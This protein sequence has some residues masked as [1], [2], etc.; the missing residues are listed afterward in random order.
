MGV[1]EMMNLTKDDGGNGL[2]DNGADAS[3]PHLYIGDILLDICLAGC[4]ELETTDAVTVGTR[5]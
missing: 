1:D 4:G 5:T 2:H 3:S